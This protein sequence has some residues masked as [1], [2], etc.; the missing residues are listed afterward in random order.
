[1][2]ENNSVSKDGSEVQKERM[3]LKKKLREIEKLEA[4]EAPLQP[5]QLEKVKLKA[6]LLAQLEALGPEESVEPDAACTQEHKG[7]A[8]VPLEVGKGC[9]TGKGSGKGYPTAGS[10]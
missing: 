8:E 2:G 3:K 7:N 4:Q 6:G 5:N 10:P 9:G 1:M